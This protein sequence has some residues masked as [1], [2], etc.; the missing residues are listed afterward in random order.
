MFPFFGV[1]RVPASSFPYFHFFRFSVVFCIVFPFP[2][3]P[4]TSSPRRRILFFC[5]G[6]SVL[7]P[8]RSA[9]DHA[10]LGIP[11]VCFFFF[12]TFLL[13]MCFI[14]LFSSLPWSGRR[15]FSS[16]LFIAG[17][18][19][20][21]PWFLFRLVRRISLLMNDEARLIPGIF[22]QTYGTTAVFNYFVHVYI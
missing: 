11:L 15:F 14:Y 3:P 12:L 1:L 4:L 8:P 2:L 10:K 20:P 22:I 6:D 9:C 21:P 17:I 13:F 5:L 19:M 18:I 16:C 7:H